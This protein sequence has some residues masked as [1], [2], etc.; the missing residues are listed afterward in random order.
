MKPEIIPA[1]DNAMREL[2]PGWSITFKYEHC[3]WSMGFKDPNGDA[4]ILP[5]H[6]WEGPPGTMPPQPVPFEEMIRQFVEHAKAQSKG[7]LT[8]T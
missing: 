4:P 1:L 2:P 3:C 5:C 6:I 7:T 8:T